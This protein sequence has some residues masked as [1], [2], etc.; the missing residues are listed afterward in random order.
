MAGLIP[1]NRKRN[2]LENV[3]FRDFSN[4]LDDFFADSWPF[5]RSL[6]GDTFKLDIQDKK[7]EYI[8]DAELPGFKKE[9]IDIMLSEGKLRL[10]VKHAEESE[11]KKNEYVHRERKCC[12]MS[13]T[14]LLADADNDAKSIKAKL[15]DGVLSVVIPKKEIIETSTKIEIE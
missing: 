5:Q 4:M 1:F 13:R 8:V 11:D 7:K 9:D 12:A 2:E 14:I 6:G 10:S 15:N 3:G